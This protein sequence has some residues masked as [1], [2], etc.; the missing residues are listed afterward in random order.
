MAT[1]AASRAVKTSLAAA[2]ANARTKV[3]TLSLAGASAG[4]GVGAGAAGMPA[5]GAVSPGRLRDGHA[6]STARLARWL[7]QS[8]GSGGIVIF[9]LSREPRGGKKIPGSRWKRDQR[10]TEKSPPAGAFLTGRS[11]GRGSTPTPGTGGNDSYF[12]KPAPGT[13]S[14]GEGNPAPLEQPGVQL[15]PPGA[16]AAVPEPAT[17]VLLG[18]GLL[19][20]GLA[21]RRKAA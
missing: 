21:C 17:L 13:I 5:C 11:A 4:E 8:S 12:L 6:A 15:G 2:R 9:R 20:L 1:G 10:Q 16:S 18:T 14:D 3:F 19:G 7:G